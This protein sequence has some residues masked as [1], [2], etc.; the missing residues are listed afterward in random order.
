MATDLQTSSEPSMSSLL[1]G[2]FSDVQ[3]LFKQQMALFKTEVR[4]DVRRTGQATVY[5]AVGGVVLFVGV[6]LLCLMAVYALEA[7]TTLKLWA[8]FGIVGGIIASLGGALVVFGRE[9][10]LS[11]NPL[12]DESLAALQENLEWTTKPK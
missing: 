12:P 1:S 2:I 6:I 9:K 3:E 7:Y 10:F 5:L 4:S 8:C 11:I